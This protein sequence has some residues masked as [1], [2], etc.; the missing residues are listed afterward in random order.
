MDEID[1]LFAQL[2][3][4]RQ[5]GLWGDFSACCRRLSRLIE[6]MAEAHSLTWWNLL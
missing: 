4:F 3:V 5:A 2:E 6:A 1:S